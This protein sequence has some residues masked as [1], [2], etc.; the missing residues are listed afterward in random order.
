MLVSLRIQTTGEAGVDIPLASPL[1]FVGLQVGRDAAAPLAQSLVSWAVVVVGLMLVVRPSR[2]LVRRHAPFTAVLAAGLLSALVLIG[3][4]GPNTYIVFKWTLTA[5]AVVMPLVLAA[6]VARAA[7][8]HPS[9][10]PELRIGLA[11]VG[12]VALAISLST[13]RGSDM[14]ARLELQGLSDDERLASVEV[15]NIDMT[16][17]YSN[18]MA[19]LLVPAQG[20]VVTRPSYADPDAPVGDVYLVQR[21]QLDGGAY[22]LIEVLSDRY[23]LAR[24]DLALDASTTLEVGTDPASR[25]YLAGSWADVGGDEVW[26]RSAVSWIVVDP[27]GDLADTDLEITL[28]GLRLA[29]AQAPRPLE[30]GTDSGPLTSVELSADRDAEVTVDVPATLVGDDGRL[31]LRL[32][33]DG[34]GERIDLTDLEFALESITVTP[35]GQTP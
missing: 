15:L 16:D 19:P 33:I 17:Y 4:W 11:T 28:R 13:M 6:A 22:E 20:V 23:A 1:A 2:E 14:G 31:R 24:R 5:V 26:A 32:Y 8:R 35:A 3:R 21:A 12:A 18:S 7:R 29:P 30:I 34:P 25:R 27:G 10:L 9:R